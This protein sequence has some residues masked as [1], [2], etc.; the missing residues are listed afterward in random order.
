MAEAEPIVFVIDDDPE[1]RISTARLIRSAD[2]QVETFGSAQEFLSSQHRNGAACLVL[3]VR[4]P[5]LSGL[6]LLEAIRQ[7]LERDHLT[8][9]QRAEVVALRRRYAQLPPRERDV[10]A[11]VVAGLLNKQIA[12]ELGTSESTVKV[13]RYR[14]MHK[15]QAESLA[16]LVRMAEK[17]NTPPTT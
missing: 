14:V 5:G 9:R 13:H 2:L 16:D 15:M 8:R 11:Q 3:D 4:L 17:L 6:D 7:A 12:A 1:V 10:M